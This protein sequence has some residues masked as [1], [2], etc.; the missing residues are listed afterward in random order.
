MFHLHFLFP[1]GMN[2]RCLH[3]TGKHENGKMK[4]SLK[5]KKLIRKYFRE[6]ENFTVAVIGSRG[7]DPQ[8][9]VC[10]HNC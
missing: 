6:K 10:V 8:S 7:V 3:I 9:L 5:M 1:G 2:L 4:Q